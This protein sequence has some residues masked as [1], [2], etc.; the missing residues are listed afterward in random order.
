[1]AKKRSTPSKSKVSFETLLQ[2]QVKSERPSLFQVVMLNDDYTPVEFVV[3]LM[4]EVFHQSAT[5][6]I[7]T[8][9]QI[10]NIGSAVC[11]EY[12][13]EIAETKA[14]EV[15]EAARAHHYPLQCI[16]ERI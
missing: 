10:H 3:N 12:I 14:A 4:E 2:D 5:E 11:G 7:E 9:M 1:M 13:H 8:T 15:I 16:L 6:A